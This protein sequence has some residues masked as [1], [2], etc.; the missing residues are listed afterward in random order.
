[1]ANFAFFGAP[2]ALFCSVDR[3]MGPPQWSDLGMLLQTV[4]PLLR[5]EVL[6]ARSLRLS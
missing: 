4:M 5:A 1:M 3:R 2:V 6:R